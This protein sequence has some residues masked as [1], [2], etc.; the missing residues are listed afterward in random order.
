MS[1]NRNWKLA[2]NIQAPGLKNLKKPERQAAKDHNLRISANIHAMF[3]IFVLIL[4]VSQEKQPLLPAG[5]SLDSSLESQVDAIS[6]SLA[7][8][9]KEE[10]LV[11]AQGKASAAAWAN[12]L[13]RW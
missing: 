5:V 3:N 8:T 6:E 4:S 7:S 10:D 1:V 2:K 9:F 11:V 12:V 13:M